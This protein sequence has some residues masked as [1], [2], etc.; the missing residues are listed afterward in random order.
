MLGYT[1]Q[2]GIPDVLIGSVLGKG[3]CTVK[4]IMAKSGTRITVRFI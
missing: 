2:I 1:V 3:G 4:E